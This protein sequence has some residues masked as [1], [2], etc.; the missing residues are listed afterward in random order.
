[1][2]SLCDCH[3]QCGWGEI[4]SNRFG[5]LNFLC[6]HNVLSSQVD[7][8]NLQIPEFNSEVRS[9]QE[10]NYIK[11]WEFPNILQK[12]KEKEEI[13]NS[14]DEQIFFGSDEYSFISQMLYEFSTLIIRNKINEDELLF[15]ITKR[16]GY[17]TYNLSE[18][19]KSDLNFRTQF[20]IKVINQLLTEEVIRIN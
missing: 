12:I 6:I 9:F 2:K 1:M 5:I 8:V 14:F 15:K 16:W 20:K 11:D 3:G 18:E 10:S 7:F 17:E 19:Q 13:E 4:Y